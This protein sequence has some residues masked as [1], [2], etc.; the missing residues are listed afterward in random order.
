MASSS[1]VENTVDA[2]G[3]VLDDGEGEQSGAGK[4]SGFEEVGGEDGVCLAAQERGPGLLAGRGVV[5][6]RCRGF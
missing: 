4:C 3:G 5:L 2:A 6:G 1:S